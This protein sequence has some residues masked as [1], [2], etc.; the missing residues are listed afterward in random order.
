ML[1]TQFVTAVRR[2]GQ[3]P[4]DLTDA[5]IL[6]AG[7]MEIQG[8]LVPLIRQVHAE[9]FVAEAQ[10]AS[11][12][13]R[14]PL[15]ARSIVGSVRHVQL[16]SGSGS[17]PLPQVQLEEDF[18]AGGAGVPYGWYFDGGNVVL[19]PRGTDGTVRFR[20]YVR[21]S[22]MTVA[23]DDYVRVNSTV[24][25]AASIDLNLSGSAPEPTPDT[26]L[27]VVSNRGSHNVCVIDQPTSADLFIVIPNSALLG[28]VSAGDYLVLA[29]FTP[30]VPLPEELFAALVHQTTA[31]LLRALGYDSE[32]GA[33]TAFAEK[34]LAGAQTLLA[35]RSEG[36]VLRRVGGIRAAIGQG[37][38]RK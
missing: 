15:P 27:D 19:L 23:A 11:H 13:G 20:Y 6:A 14:V 9:Y 2:Q 37:W 32:S 8:A 24:I 25:N 36:N 30:V 12:L 21:P 26:L 28:P 10:I 18:L 7:D 38:R 29:G 3:F 31:A 35:P 1:A 16:V 17:V 5:S 4:A 22:A 34:A 33:Q